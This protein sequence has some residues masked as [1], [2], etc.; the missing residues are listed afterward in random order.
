MARVRILGLCTRFACQAKESNNTH[1]A[2][3]QAMQASV[4][5]ATVKM[6]P[7]VYEGHTRMNNLVNTIFQAETFGTVYLDG[8]MAS[9]ILTVP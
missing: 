7:G 1:T 4:P 2:I 5:S 8:L 9:R 3:S 6:L